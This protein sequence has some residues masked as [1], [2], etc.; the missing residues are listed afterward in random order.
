MRGGQQKP[1]SATESADI[2]KKTLKLGSPILRPPTIASSKTLAHR[3][4][5]QF[6]TVDQDS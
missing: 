5:Q 3:L 2:G 4:L 6:L 1:P